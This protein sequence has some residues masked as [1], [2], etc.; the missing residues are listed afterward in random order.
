M[1][2]EA[3]AFC[4]KLT[5]SRDEGDDLYQ[6]ALLAALDRIRTLRRPESFRPWLYRIIVNCFKNRRRDP[7]WRR[8][9]SLTENQETGDQ[10]IDPSRQYAARSLLERAFKAVT[11]QEKALIILFEIEE[12]SIAELSELYHSRAG[13]IKSRLSRA[14]HKMRDELMRYSSQQRTANLQSEGRYAMPGSETATE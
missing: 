11:P 1:H 2:P 4:R 12:W 3:E 6:D 9:V 5:G 10:A 8:R 13:T 14:R 7:W